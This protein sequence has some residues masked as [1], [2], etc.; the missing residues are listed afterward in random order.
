[1]LVDAPCSR[2]G[3]PGA[4]SS[5]DEIDMLLPGRVT[6]DGA[7]RSRPPEE[8]GGGGG[9]TRDMD[10]GALYWG[11]GGSI[12]RPLKGGG[13]GGGGCSCAAG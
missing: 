1:M 4:E 5:M 7:G 9:G 6:E 10:A 12:G 3:L 11:E 8:K 2:D 13:G